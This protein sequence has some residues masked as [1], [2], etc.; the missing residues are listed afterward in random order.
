M[1]KNFE[2]RKYFSDITYEDLSDPELLNEFK[3]RGLI[4]EEDENNLADFSKGIK[5][6]EGQFE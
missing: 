6:S 5:Y 2:L 4:D 1:I 3:E